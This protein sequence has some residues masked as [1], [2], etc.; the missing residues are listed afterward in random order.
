[1]PKD[2]KQSN[3]Q[4]SDN[5]QRRPPRNQ[6][7]DLTSTDKEKKRRRNTLITVISIFVLIS[8][9]IGIGYYLIYVMPFQ[10][11]II[12]VDNEA[13][14]INY[15]LKRALNSSS[16][17][18]IGQGLLETLVNEIIIKLESPNFGIDVTEED[19]ETELRNA[20]KGESESITDAE[21]DAWYR[22]LLNNTQ[23][24][25]KQ[26]HEIVKT[27]IQ[28]QRV[29]QY[30]TDTTPKTAEHGYIWTIVVQ[31][32]EEA[33]AAK[34][35]IDNGEEFASVARE[36]SRD[37]TTSEQGGE[38]GWVPFKALESRFEY[39]LTGL[40]IGK[41][42]EP[43]INNMG[44]ETNPESINYAVFM[45]SEIDVARE[46]SEDY[47]GTL[48]SR[49]YADWLNNQWTTREIK[50]FSIDGGNYDDVTQAWLNYQLRR[51][52]EGLGTTEE[53][54]ET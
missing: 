44:D 27:S 34:E 18:P 8:L 36:I 29:M 49:A 45:V 9:V 7:Q 13:I 47:L 19:I 21:Y 20:A 12:K 42:S 48:Q 25:E 11:T 50:Y 15:L 22:Q 6:S 24:S 3:T 53:T 51:M 26:L 23:Y 35:R 43:V 16:E 14:K 4:S 40:E 28:Q 33:L 39:A 2:I 37:S 52:R 46:V 10:R 31:T 32:Y 5:P 54:S 1:M 30:F 41:C 17:D 38:I